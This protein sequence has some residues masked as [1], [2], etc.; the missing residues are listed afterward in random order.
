MDNPY[1]YPI[2]IRLERVEGE[3]INGDEM[4]V[5][6]CEYCPEL[7]KTHRNARMTG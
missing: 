1:H 2:T 5:A 3:P 6:R 7:A 4:F